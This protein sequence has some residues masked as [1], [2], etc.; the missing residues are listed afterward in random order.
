MSTTTDFEMLKEII[1]GI[2]GN[3]VLLPEIPVDVFNQEAEDLYHVAIAD[4]KELSGRGLK[5]KVIESL[6][7]AAGACRY[8]EAQWTKERNAK[9]EAEL[10]W[11]EKSPEAY[12]LRN[13]LIYEFEFAFIHNNNLI[14]VV[15]RIKSDSGHSDMIQDLVTLTLLGKE[16]TNLLNA[17]N[18]DS[19]LLLKAESMAD[20]M[21]DLLGRANG[22][23]NENNEAKTMRDKA[24]THLKGL[25]DE[26]RRYGKFVFRKDKEHAAKYASE[27]KRK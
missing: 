17:I 16:N 1:A 6:T 24:Y 2:N 7:V 9:Q 15:D 3:Q 5:L 21:A 13:D 25:V 12:G 27:Y 8:A 23:K 22:T 20:Q 10:E 19:S 4:K 18:F 26:V 14:S 11:K